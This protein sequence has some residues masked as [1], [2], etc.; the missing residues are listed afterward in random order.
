MKLK[1]LILIA[2]LPITAMAQGDRS[3][4]T[5]ATSGWL[6]QD[7][8]LAIPDVAPLTK[9]GNAQI[10]IRRPLGTPVAVDVFSS[11]HGGTA[12]WTTQTPANTGPFF[13]QLLAAGHIIVQLRFLNDGWFTSSPGVL[14]GFKVMACYPA[15]AARWIRHNIAGGLPMQWVGESGGSAQV[16]YALNVYAADSFIDHA[17]L[18]SGPPFAQLCQGCTNVAGETLEKSAKAMVDGTDGYLNGNGPCINSSADPAWCQFW[19]QDSADTGDH[20]DYP[21]TVVDMIL[22]SKDSPTTILNRARI[23]WNI[24]ASYPDHRGTL[25]TVTGMG[26]SITAWPAGLNLLRDNLI[27]FA[28]PPPA[29]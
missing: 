11:G 28:T 21:L 6:I 12:F 9:L 15:T 5:V 3:L 14:Y 8:K 27:A 26:H 23:Y 29:Q 2:I 10:A 25:T 24:L 4:G 7:L 16:A 17:I 18:I 13:E 20:F 22:G 1:T 19:T